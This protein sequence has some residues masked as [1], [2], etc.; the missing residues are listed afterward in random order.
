MANTGT[1]KYVARLQRRLITLA[2][3]PNY[4]YGAGRV[5]CVMF[6][7]REVFFAVGGYTPEDDCALV[8]RHEPMVVGV[9]NY[10]LGTSDFRFACLCCRDREP[11]LQTRGNQPF[12]GEQ[13]LLASPNSGG[14]PSL[15]RMMSLDP[16]FKNDGRGNMLGHSCAGVTSGGTL[17]KGCKG[18]MAAR[19]MDGGQ[20]QVSFALD[21]FYTSKA[22]SPQGRSEANKSLQAGAASRRPMQRSPRPS[23]ALAWTRGPEEDER[24]PERVSAHDGL[25]CLR[26]RF[27][28]GST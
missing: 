18:R 23:E 11:P 24:H 28:Q 7:G 9:D 12:S 16:L 4:L 14:P 8:P 13:L 10:D 17:I 1:Y 19:R 15:P 22:R 3:K 5:F 20:T 27:G 6:F 26:R 21:A 25:N 2:S